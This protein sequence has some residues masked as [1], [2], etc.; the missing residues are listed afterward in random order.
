MSL[1]KLNYDVYECIKMVPSWGSLSMALIYL[2]SQFIGGSKLCHLPF[3]RNKNHQ[4]SISD[5]VAPL[6][7]DL[8]SICRSMWM[9]IYQRNKIIYW[10]TSRDGQSFVST[11]SKLTSLIII[12]KLRLVE[13][14]A[15]FNDL[16]CYVCAITFVNPLVTQL[17]STFFFGN[18]TKGVG[19][20]AR[21]C[22][23]TKNSPLH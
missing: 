13:D 20:Q 22:T 14:Q 23:Y 21:A 11:L 19:T 10:N 12:N 5:R 17:A 18:P 15:L 16:L 8:D 6:V 1:Q 9:S 3:H 7:R 2:S 4:A